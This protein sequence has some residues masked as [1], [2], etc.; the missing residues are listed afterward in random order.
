[1]EILPWAIAALPLILRDHADALETEAG[2][3][4]DA[5]DDAMVAAYEIEQELR[6]PPGPRR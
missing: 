3:L 4:H 6:G 5:A 1:M 2:R